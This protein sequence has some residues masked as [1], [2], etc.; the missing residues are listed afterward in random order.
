MSTASLPSYRYEPRDT[1]HLL[2]ARRTPYGANGASDAN[3]VKNSRTGGVILRL[4]GQRAGATLPE[5][6][7]AGVVE[8]TVELKPEIAEGALSVDVKVRTCV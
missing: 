6:G 5:Y 7:R 8:G 4:S 1:E 2:A 3:F